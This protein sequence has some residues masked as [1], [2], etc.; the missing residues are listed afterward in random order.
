MKWS[1]P[2]PR[3]PQGTWHANRQ[4]QMPR[5]ICQTYSNSTCLCLGVSGGVC[6]CLL[7]SVGMLCSL[8]MPRGYL[9]NVWGVP[10]GYLI[11]IHRNWRRSNVFG[12]YVGSQS[13]S[14]EQKHYLGTD[15]KGITFVIWPYWGIEISKWSHICFPKMVG[16]CHFL[17]FLG[18]PE[19]NYSSQLLWITL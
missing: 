4:Q 9:G 12:G 13:Y 6:L 8:E 15:L 17:W 7:V 16:L 2:T 19:K 1:S 10:E 11:G 14:M 3:H 18:S 5:D